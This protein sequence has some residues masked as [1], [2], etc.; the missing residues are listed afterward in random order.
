MNNN[1]LTFIAKN[2]QKLNLPTQKITWIIQILEK[3]SLQKVVKNWTTQNEWVLYAR[4]W[5]NG[6]NTIPESWTLQQYLLNQI[7]AIAGSLIFSS[8]ILGFFVNKWWLLLAMFVGLNLF[9]YSLSGF[10]PLEIILKKLQK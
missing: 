8:S 4:S 1:L 9:Q 6:W 10:C 3:S 2:I 5:S 7:N